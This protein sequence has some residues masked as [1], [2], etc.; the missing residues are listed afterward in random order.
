M[1]VRTYSENNKIVVELEG[2]RILE[3]RPFFAV[4]GEPKYPTAFKLHEEPKSTKFITEIDNIR[5]EIVVYHCHEETKAPC[6]LL[7]K[8]SCSNGISNNGLIAGFSDVNLATFKR[9]LLYHFTYTPPKYFDYKFDHKFDYPVATDVDELR[10]D[11]WS[12]PWHTED[13]NVLPYNL[14]VSQ[15]LFS[16]PN[17]LYLFLLPITNAG[18]RGYISHLR[19]ESLMCFSMHTARLHGVTHLSSL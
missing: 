14:K 9:A 11:P 1:H 5:C 6:I 15:I 8:V 12:Y 7:F 10:Y 17:G 18:C 19:K 13:L 3:F 16:I 2:A 4:K